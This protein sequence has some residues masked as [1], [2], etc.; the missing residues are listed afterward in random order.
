M[1]WINNIIINVKYQIMKLIVYKIYK[2]FIGLKFQM[3]AFWK[4]LLVNEIM[5]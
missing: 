4:A 1:F 5:Y 2:S 3:K